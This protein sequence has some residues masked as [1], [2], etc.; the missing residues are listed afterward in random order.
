MK[1]DSKELYRQLTAPFSEKEIE[2]RL[3][4]VVNPEKKTGLAVPY[5][6]CRAIQRRLDETVGP[7]NWQTE[8]RSWIAI[9]NQPSNLCV[10]S[11]YMED[12]KEW[13]SKSDGA[14]LTQEEPVKGGLSG[15]FKRAAVLWG[16][17]RYLY[18][19]DAQFVDVEEYRKGKWR[20]SRDS[21]KKLESYYLSWIGRGTSPPNPAPYEYVVTSIAQE[22]FGQSM[23]LQD[24]KKVSILAVKQGTDRAL[25]KGVRLTRVRLTEYPGRD[26]VKVLSEYKIAA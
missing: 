3:Q 13:V 1:V 7:F 9:E 14:A 6:Q 19:M 10:L 2:W 17:G 18:D 4:R 24:Q 12:R 8:F 21:I 5:V 15:A 22:Q 11:V 23:V 25:A 26:D 16:I 20:M